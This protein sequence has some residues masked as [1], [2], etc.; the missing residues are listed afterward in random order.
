MEFNIT[1]KISRGKLFGKEQEICDMY[2]NQKK[3]LV[4]VSEYFGCDNKIIRVLFK[5][6]NLKTRSTKGV[7]KHKNII[8]NEKDIIELYLSGWASIDIA[9]K[10][11]V[12]IG[13]ILNCLK[14]NNIKIRNMSE[15]R[16]TE[17]VREKDKFR[18]IKFTDDKTTEIINYY[19][20]GY[21]ANELGDMFKCDSTVIKKLI[22]DNGIKFRSLDSMFTERTKLK[23]KTTFFKKFGNWTERNLYLNEKLQEKY[24]DGITGAMQIPDFFH[25]NQSSGVRIK[26]YTVNGIEISYRGYELKAIFRLLDEGYNINDLI[27]GKG[28]P[29]IRYTFNGK[30][31]RVYYPDIY[32]PKDNRLIE[33]KSKWTFE[34]HKSKNMAKMQAVIDSGYFFDFYIMDKTDYPVPEL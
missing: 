8:G 15:A 34:Q 17:K 16:T 10:Y 4:E 32:I 22:L 29:T 33:V 3:T 12:D 11:S 31:N 2:F 21:S 27:I 5:N 6:N 1:K 19:T 13:T 18:G 7:N 30:S 14:F 20:E 25:K 26:K 23:A 24:G 28:V 9:E